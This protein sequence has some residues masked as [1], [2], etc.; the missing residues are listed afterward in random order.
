MKRGPQSAQS[1][2]Y[3]QLPPVTP[4]AQDVAAASATLFGNGPAPSADKL[5]W[6]LIEQIAEITL[7]SANTDALESI[8]ANFSAGCYSVSADIEGLYIGDFDLDVTPQANGVLSAAVTI[9][10][11]RL[12]WHASG[13]SGNFFC[14]DWGLSGDLD[15]SQPGRRHIRDAD[16]T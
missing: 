6:H 11:L 13:S 10:D 1:V 4:A 9:S 14:P 3:A 15:Y 8:Q 7:N 12:D 2:P 16:C 5:A